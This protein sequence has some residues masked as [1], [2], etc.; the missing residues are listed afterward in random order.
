[1]DKS[2]LREELVKIVGEKNYTDDELDILS[3]SSDM[4]ALPEE[5]LELYGFKKAE[6]IVLPQTTEHVAAIVELAN[7]TGIPLTLRG[8][9]STGYGGSVPVSGG[10]I[11]DLTAMKKVIEL[12]EKDKT[13]TVQCG[14]T[15]KELLNFL[16]KK[17]Y[18]QGIYPSSAYTATIGGFIS[19]GGSAGIGAPKYGSIAKQVIGL[20]VVLANGKT[21]DTEN[22]NLPDVERQN[23]VSKLFIGSEG[24]FGIITEAKLRIYPEEKGFVACT[25]A[26]ND[27]DSALKSTSETLHK[28]VVPHTLHV[29]DSAF[30]KNL[31][32][33]GVESPD[34]DAMILTAFE[35]P[36]NADV[37]RDK[38]AFI[39]I[40]RNNGGK[41]LGSD[42]ADREWAHR[43]KIELLF[44]RLGPTMIP[45]EVLSSV[46]DASKIIKSWK[47]T[48]ND[49]KVDLSIFAILGDEQQF[50]LMPM[51]LV[52]ELNKG[53]FV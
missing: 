47:K 11:L 42:V 48:A 29:M 31:K 43:Y 22:E 46:E 23:D 10:V 36:T 14:M 2:S 4:G 39:K 16:S 5:I 45:L 51:A 17:G 38:T 41:E 9:A 6:Y 12:N 33:A 27:L 53:Q 50:L 34:V 40:C 32:K 28:K 49:K 19:M 13:V 30:L 24:I 26:F 1:M 37:D 25:V 52:N 20:K 18:H 7:K 8:G 44:K 21:V 3:Y 35:G 15:C